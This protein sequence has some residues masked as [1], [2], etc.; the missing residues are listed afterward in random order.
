MSDLAE[1]LGRKWME[2]PPRFP[3]RYDDAARWW[4]KAIA[5]EL[6]AHTRDFDYADHCDLASGYHDAARWLRS[7]ISP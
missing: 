6:E 5:D 4:L 7:E 3:V 1:R 2:E